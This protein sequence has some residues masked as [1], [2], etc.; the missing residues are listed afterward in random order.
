M[1][2][3]EFERRSRSFSELLK[4]VVMEPA[5]ARALP[6]RP[7]QVVTTHK[8]VVHQYIAPLTEESSQDFLNLLYNASRA[9]HEFP[10]KWGKL[11][12]VKHC[13][14]KECFP[15]RL[16][17]LDLALKDIGKSGAEGLALEGLLNRLEAGERI[18]HNEWAQACPHLERLA[19]Y[20]YD[21]TALVS[22]QF[23]LKE[24]VDSNLDLARPVDRLAMV[25]SLH[26]VGE[27]YREIS[28]ATIGLMTAQ[29]MPW[30]MRDGKKWSLYSLRNKLSHLT[31]ARLDKLVGS[32]APGASN[33]QVKLFEEVFKDLSFLK[34]LL[35]EI[36][37]S[38][39]FPAHGQSWGDFWGSLKALDADL[40]LAEP[41]DGDYPGL[42]A[43]HD[44]LTYTG[45]A[46]PTEDITETLLDAFLP[47]TD[48]Q[49]AAEALLKKRASKLWKA[50]G[51][52]IQGDDKKAQALKIQSIL[53]NKLKDVLFILGKSSVELE[54]CEEIYTEEK[55]DRRQRQLLRQAVRYAKPEDKLQARADL[56]A[57]NKAFLE[58]RGRLVR[59]VALGKPL[60]KTIQAHKVAKEKLM[61]AY[62]VHQYKP[63][64]GK[65]NITAQF[66]EY[67]DMLRDVFGQEA[68]VAYN[69][70]K[71]AN[72]LNCYNWEGEPTEL[73]KLF[74]RANKISW[75][76]LADKKAHQK[77]KTQDFISLVD[78]LG[79]LLGLE[80]AT[81]DAELN[82]K[83]VYTDDARTPIGRKE[84][85]N[86]LLQDA[87]GIFTP[88][89]TIERAEALFAQDSLSSYAAEYLMGAI[90]ELF[91]E[92]ND[93]PQTLGLEATDHV[94]NFYNHPD[95]FHQDILVSGELT[96][97]E[98]PWVQ[99]NAGKTKE[100]LAKEVG[101][102]LVNVR[103]VL[104][105]R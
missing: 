25:R 26:Y 27:I 53:N 7:S 99:E 69:K 41:Q 86:T 87:R 73:E 50:I 36:E 4:E 72:A 88:V 44:H 22:M 16:Q 66:A 56:K 98:E 42:K 18:M 79:E 78:R 64:A 60:Y 104:A 75:T 58:V 51:G 63:K 59:T 10:R 83:E 81:F 47:L 30:R 62:R 55:L 15:D 34:K 20:Y 14:D 94:R 77:A 2:E 91:K 102:L 35:N 92:I 54:V 28:D 61:R 74:Y 1:P 23:V 93:Y 17:L 67:V 21:Y 40:Q 9:S 101:R 90:Y 80:D 19:S 65:G 100:M 24:V 48:K 46:A 31:R 39:F 43:L 52:E 33:D 11:Y 29:A 76:T 37:Q 32:V 68:L 71:D 97:G 45:A 8:Q 84:I 103:Y 5:R 38:Y 70:N 13:I 6:I 85:E 95:P 12:E 82:N 49:K 57:L 105:N 89:L 3:N 96:Q